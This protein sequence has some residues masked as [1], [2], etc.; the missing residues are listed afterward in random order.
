MEIESIAVGSTL[1]DLFERQ[2]ARTPESIALVCGA[3][4]WSYR[5]L[6]GQ[7]NRLA[8]G[9]IARGVGPERLVAL[10]LPRGAEM[11]LAV[12][13][14]AKAGAAFLPLD[15]DYPEERLNL[16]LDGARPMVVLV[17]AQCALPESVAGPRLV[18]DDALTAGPVDVHPAHPV[19]DAERTGPVHLDQTAYVIYTSGSTGR[20]KGVVVTHRG[21]ANLDWAHRNRYGVDASAVVLQLASPGFDALVSEL[22]MALLTG[23]R[24]VVSDGEPLVPG[25]GLTALVREHGVTHVTVSPTMLT[26]FDEA[27]LPGVG[28]LIV[29]GEACPP[30]TAARWSRGRTMVNAYGPTESTVCATASAPLDGRGTP[31]IGGPITD[32]QVH[33]LDE[34]LQPVPAGTA[35]ELYLAG[36][37]LARGYLDRPGLTSTRFVADP[38]AGPGSRMYRTGDLVRQDDQGQLHF[39]GRSDDQIKIHGFRVEPAE[40]EAVLGGM[41][42]V[43]HAAVVVR[44][45]TPGDRR[46]VAYVV[47][48]PDATVPPDPA[49][50]RSLSARSLPPHMVPTAVVCLP[51]LP[52]T[53]HGK[54][55][56]RALPAPT[57]GSG[58]APE[59]V[60]EVALAALFAELLGIEPGRVEAGTGFFELGNSLLAIRLLGRLRNDYGVDLK[61]RDFYEAQTVEAL[62][63]RLETATQPAPRRPLEPRARGAADPVSF[64]QERLWLLNLFNGAGA[65]Y[66]IPFVHRVV[67]DLDDTALALAVRDVVQRHEALRTVFREVDD[68]PVQ[69]V[70]TPEEV[71][72]GAVFASVRVEPDRLQA[73]IDELCAYPFD[74]ERGPALLVRLLRLGPTE[75]VLVVVVHHIAFDGWSAGP[76]FC[77]LSDAYTA[78]AAGRAPTWEPLP[79]QYADF[80]HWQRESLGSPNDAQSLSS[81]QAAFWREALAGLPAEVLPPTDRA[82]PQAPSRRADTV[83]FTLPATLCTALERFGRLEDAS[84]FMAV[85]TAVAVTLARL[86]AGEDIP[87]GMLVA[88]RSEPVLDDVVG[89]FVNTLVL[90]SDLSGG[91]SL[92]EVLRRVRGTDL[93]AFAHQDVPFDRVVTALRPPRQAGRNPLF[94]F[95]LVYQDGSGEPL[96]L[97]D[98]ACESL[99]V[100]AARVKFDVLLCL[101]RTTDGGMSGYF[102]FATD[103]YDRATVEGWCERLEQVVADAGRGPDAPALG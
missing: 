60:H 37:G 96:C 97:G 2:V 9:L 40:I 49:T 23:A 89:F 78:R 66:N 55:D 50:L 79:V 22:C 64:A 67:G 27:G 34:K 6:D 65:E 93:A 45:D 63:K 101:R 54:L 20:P 72:A 8:R 7:A 47:P 82:R 77:D 95:M 44:E 56:R 99:Q 31:D 61:M 84:F 58:R 18:L 69:R 100:H 24:L 73:K 41:D 85:Q 25:E 39:V 28:T 62:A 74:L 52:R 13:A 11:V 83:D 59:G 70:L 71:E 14:V 51:F 86:G 4:R 19:T 94:Q 102:E 91:P 81:R 98:T 10:A 57:E 15:L 43:A 5:E 33:V 32:T 17:S 26:E 16:V 3:R 21:I 75:A 30:E 92:R 42:Q 87:L 1:A 12:L 76:L 38:F 103:L 46:L 68:A 35:G 90:R 36:S 29:A 48:S 53:P 88:G 80:A